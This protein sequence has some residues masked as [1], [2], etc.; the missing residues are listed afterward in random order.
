[1]ETTLDIAKLP[2]VAVIVISIFGAAPRPTVAA[3]VT[4]R[5]ASVAFGRLAAGKCSPARVVTFSNPNR[6]AVNI[7]QVSTSG[8]FRLTANYCGSVLAPKKTCTISVS[9]SPATASKP[10][11]T[12]QTGKLT[13]VGEGR[14]PH[15]SVKLVGIAT[16]PDSDPSPTAT[17]TNTAT[18]TDTP[19][20]SPTATATA[21]ATPGPV[22]TATTTPTATLTATATE[23]A[24]ATAT[25]SATATATTTPTSTATATVTATPTST[26]TSPSTPSPT[27]TPQVNGCSPMAPSY[28]CA[29]TFAGATFDQQVNACIAA[30]PAS[31]GI[32][33]ARAL[34][35]N[36]T[37]QA[38]V[39]LT[40]GVTILLPQGSINQT[41][42]SAFVYFDDSRLIGQGRIVTTIQ[43]QGGGPAITQGIPGGVQYVEVRE[44]SIQGDGT[45]GSVALNLTQPLD[46]VFENIAISNVD[47]GVVL[48]PDNPWGCA[49]YN[50][51]RD[52]S[53]QGISYGIRML[54]GSQ[55]NRVSGGQAWASNG[56]GLTMMNAARADKVDIENSPV[57]AIVFAGVES[58]VISPYIETSGPIILNS[59]VYGNTLIGAG[60]STDI[61]D[62]SGSDLNSLSNPSQLS[63]Y[64]ADA[65]YGL[66]IGGGS[67]LGTADYLLE[68]APDASGL[69][70]SYGTNENAQGH[71][72]PA[73][74]HASSFVSNGLDCPLPAN[75]INGAVFYGPHCDP[76]TDPPGQCTSSGARSG[77]WVHGTAGHW[78]CVP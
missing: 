6:A 19:A 76:A 35:V 29:D 25:S 78:I 22:A 26:A 17:A 42:G 70:L 40:T 59:G 62:N 60:A 13:V 51:F 2:L 8:P 10:S 23:T 33:D 4:V 68:G 65:V 50:E 56:V 49:C 38:N 5:P 1:M 14:V 69:Y 39:N 47:T 16:G 54:P 46:G 74:L 71:V 15:R 45:A 58:T 57:A 28:L 34:P 21:I 27:P 24:T 55:S 77:A 75:V 53:A 48:G 9:F 67:S 52:V 37:M 63:A 3:M 18:P 7:Q 11:G 64:W 43:H 31:G 12:K 66:R 32:C 61:Q 41:G 44:L 20:A 72:G 36:T 30:L 73:P